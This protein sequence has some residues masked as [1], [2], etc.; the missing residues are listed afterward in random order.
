MVKKA[1]PTGTEVEPFDGATPA[2]DAYKAVLF[3]QCD[4]I[5]ASWDG[6][7]RGDLDSIHELRVGLRRSTAVL[8]AASRVFDEET[9]VA[10]RQQYRLVG[11]LT[12]DARDLDVLVLG[13]TY[14]E[15]PYSSLLTEL[16]SQQHRAHTVLSEALRHR[17]LAGYVDRVRAAV[18]AAPP[19]SAG[20]EPLRNVLPAAIERQH[21]ALAHAGRRLGKR[22]SDS[23]LH[24][25]RKRAKNLRY[26]TA[27][28]A[29]VLDPDP[30]A[31]YHHRLKALQDVLGAHHDAS[32][33]AALIR[34]LVLEVRGRPSERAA[35]IAAAGE[36]IEG[37]DARKD[38]AR[39]D[40]EATFADFDRRKP[41]RL[42]RASLDPLSQS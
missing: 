37:C 15:E 39:A 18:R 3:R 19:G 11:R 10:L 5:A 7:V 17:E 20:V 16:R 27:C 40:F 42:L 36:V 13:W 26:L 34:A 31:R 9:R 22:A 30:L 24:G 1:G 41:R 2:C 28:F 8:G 6:A 21:R 23:Q 25:L 4:D 12:G 14:T 33:Q 29:E 35:A 32:V 38:S